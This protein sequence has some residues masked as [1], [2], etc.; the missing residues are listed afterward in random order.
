MND[1]LEGGKTYNLAAPRTEESFG[2]H[3][4]G[5]F[6]YGYQSN[7]GALTN[8]PPNETLAGALVH[9]TE[10]A[11]QNYSYSFNSVGS[12]SSSTSLSFTDTRQ[13]NQALNRAVSVNISNSS[14]NFGES[15]SDHTAQ[16]DYL[17][18]FTTAGA[19]YQ[20]EYSKTF[21][22]ESFGIDKIPEFQV[23]PFDFFQHFFIPMSAQLTFGEY[24]EPT[25]LLA[26]WRGDAASYSDRN[27]RTC[28]I[29]ISRRPS[30]STN[31]HQPR[32]PQGSIPA[33]R[34]PDD[35]DRASHR[36]LDYLQRGQL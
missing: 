30:T 26:T 35:A 25:S 13:F 27:S 10:K 32:G 31:T 3:L 14:T 19:D 6:Q 1:R 7:Y 22:Q 23:R 15:S 29:A 18:H 16:F 33:R 2:Q 4:R 36:Q 17:M 5:N 28:L 11:S 8:V 21:A 34:E 20:M 24:S 12:Q 9:Q